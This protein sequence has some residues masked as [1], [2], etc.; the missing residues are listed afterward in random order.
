VDPVS[1][2]AL[3]AALSQS[4]AGRRRVVLA[5]LLGMLGGL[6]PDLDVLIRSEQDPLL[7][8]EYHRQFTHALVFIPVGAWLCAVVAHGFVRRHLRFRE[9]W[10]Y[11]GLGYATHGLLD[12]CTSYGTQL[13]WPFSDARIAW[14]HI[15]VIDPLFTL[16]LLGL[17]VAAALRRRPRLAAY[18]LLWAAVYIG[19]G[20]AQS[21]RVEARAQALAHA[22]GHAPQLLTVK[23][24]FGNILMWKSIYAAEG[25]F[26]VDAIRAGWTLTVWP[27]ARTPQLDPARDLPWLD[28]TSRQARDLERFRWFSAG[29]IAQPDDDPHKVVDIRYSML[30]NEIDALWGIRLDP[31]AAPAD[32]VAFFVNRR[33]TAAQRTELWAMLRGMEPSAAAD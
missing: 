19:L 4:V 13:L 25:Y 7:F 20:A 31:A 8:L 3:G 1:Q 2:G 14:N 28:P 9:T 17:V 27:G 6:A 10:L 21:W 33:A 23:P 12:A 30:P 22:R 26:H 29:Y 16:P 18:G 15:A 11:C 5:G 24:S 32:P